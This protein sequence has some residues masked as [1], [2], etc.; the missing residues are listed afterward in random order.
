MDRWRREAEEFAA[1][2]AA[3]KLQRRRNEEQGLREMHAREVEVARAAADGDAEIFAAVAQALNDLVERVEAVEARVDQ[4]SNGKSKNK[5]APRRKA[6]RTPVPLPGKFPWQPS[7]HPD[8][9]GVHIS[10]PLVTVRP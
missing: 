2:R 5:S 7:R 10:Q 3:A 9:P 1:A 6:K 8:W 4:L